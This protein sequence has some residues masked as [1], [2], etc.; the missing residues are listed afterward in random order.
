MEEA[1][2]L[3]SRIGIMAGGELQCV[4]SAQHLK[5][6]YGKGYTLTVNMLPT[7]D[8]ATQ[9]ENLS[10]F[11]SQTLTSGDGVLLSSINQTRKYLLPKNKSTTISRIFKTMEVNKSILGIREWGLTMSTLEDVFISAVEH[12]NTI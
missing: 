5:S 3:C 4:G 7:D 11:V 9:N 10:A 1:E 6:K 8:K 2:A 12:D